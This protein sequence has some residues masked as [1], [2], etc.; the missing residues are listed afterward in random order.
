MSKEMREIAGIIK[1][2]ASFGL[3]DVGWPVLSFAVHT[4]DGYASLQCLCGKEIEK[5][6]TENYIKDIKELKGRMVI[7]ETDGQK[8]FVKR[9]FNP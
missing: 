1:G 8:I 3:R 6:L 5:F 2:E 7:C 9:I 4:V